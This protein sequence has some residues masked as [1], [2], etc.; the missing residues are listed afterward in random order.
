MS[1]VSAFLAAAVAGAVTASIA[2]AVAVAA[3][4]TVTLHKESTQ[5]C[6]RAISM[7]RAALIE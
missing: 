7:P 4:F 5:Y 1:S 6:T 3:A 2:V